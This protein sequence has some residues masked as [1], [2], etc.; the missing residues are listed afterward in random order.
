[1]EQLRQEEEQS[2]HILSDRYTLGYLPDGQS[3]K[4]LFS[5]KKVTGPQVKQVVAFITHVRQELSQTWQVRSDLLAHFPS[6]QK[7][8]QV[9][10][11]RKELIHEVQFLALPTQLRQVG[12]QT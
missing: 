2:S 9:F 6:G 8:R 4:H 7:G 10:N 5:F 3:V 12:S 1:M 11:S